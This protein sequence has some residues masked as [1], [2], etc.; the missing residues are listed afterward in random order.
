MATAADVTAEIMGTNAPAN[1]HD[2]VVHRNGPG[3]RV[4]R[5][6]QDKITTAV[7]EITLWLPR[8][9]LSELRA[10]RGKVDT[11]LGHSIDAASASLLALEVALR[12]AKKVGADVSDIDGLDES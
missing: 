6:V 9:A 3:Q 1:H 12:V 8:R 5:T 10:K 4:A 2:V 7:A 11:N